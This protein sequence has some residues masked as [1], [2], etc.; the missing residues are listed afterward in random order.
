LYLSPPALCIA[1]DE[2]VY[3]YKR[4]KKKSPA[5]DAIDIANNG[6]ALSPPGVSDVCIPSSSL[7]ADGIYLLTHTHT[8]DALI[9]IRTAYI[10]EG[11]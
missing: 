8:Q 9:Y 7:A 3:Y 1:I 4:N 5:H 2:R 11:E 6:S 10:C